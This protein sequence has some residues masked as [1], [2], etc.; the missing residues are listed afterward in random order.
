MSLLKMCVIEKQ[1]KLFLSSLYNGEHHIL[2]P[3]VPKTCVTEILVLPKSKEKLLLMLLGQSFSNPNHN[4]KSHRNVPSS[5]LFDTDSEL[6][7]KGNKK[8]IIS[9]SSQWAFVIRGTTE[10]LE[11]KT[12]VACFGEV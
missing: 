10:N 9:D 11:C 2:C 4:A 12:S 1:C 5:E 6:W 7:K 3:S 8:G